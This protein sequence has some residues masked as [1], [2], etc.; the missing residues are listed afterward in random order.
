MPT[1]H[2]NKQATN[3]I[4][5]KTT[6]TFSTNEWM[7]CKYICVKQ[8]FH[9]ICVKVKVKYKLNSRSTYWISGCML[10]SICWNLLQIWFCQIS[11]EM[12]I[13]GNGGSQMISL[14]LVALSDD[15]VYTA[16]IYILKHP[17]EGLPIRSINLKYSRD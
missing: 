9:F 4:C 12:Q 14:L 5:W 1:H 15:S 16:V 13:M 17:G 8:I 7:T 6:V 3:P 10:Y 2:K 11:S